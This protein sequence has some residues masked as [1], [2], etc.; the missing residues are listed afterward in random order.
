MEWYDD[1]K[2][3]PVLFFILSIAGFVTGYKT[4]ETVLAGQYVLKKEIESEYVSISKYEQIQSELNALSKRLKE[5]QEALKNSQ[6][7]IT[8]IDQK[9]NIRIE[10]NKIKEKLKSELKELR[11]RLSFASPLKLDTSKDGSEDVLYNSI[12]ENIIFVEKKILLIDE[13]IIDS[14]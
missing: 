14:Y 4:C 6:N 12:K 9:E 1:A 3:H 2:K 11:E 13:K 5:T 10:L 8:R 7:K